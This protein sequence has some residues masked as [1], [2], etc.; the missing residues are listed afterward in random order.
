MIF[1]HLFRSPTADFFHCA[2]VAS[3]PTADFF[4]L[5]TIETF[6]DGNFFL[7][8]GAGFTLTESQTKTTAMHEEKQ[9]TLKRKKGKRKNETAAGKKRNND[10]SKESPVRQE[11]ERKIMELKTN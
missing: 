4:H 8:K 6:K 1:V 5:N 3:S 7:S 9:G 11:H 10:F 2:E